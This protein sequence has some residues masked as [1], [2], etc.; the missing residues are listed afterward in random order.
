MGKSPD[1]EAGVLVVVSTDSIYQLVNIMVTKG[2]QP[3]YCCESDA[4]R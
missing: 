4:D 2:Q 3:S 1:S